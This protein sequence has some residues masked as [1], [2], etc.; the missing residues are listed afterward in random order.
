MKLLASLSAAGPDGAALA[1]LYRELGLNKSTCYNILQTLR[2]H[3]HVI[4]D[5]SSKRYTLGPVLVAL[6]LQ[7]LGSI[8]TVAVCHRQLL[9]LSRELGLTCLLT[10]LTQDAH[11]LVIDRVAGAGPIKITVAIGERL[12]LTSTA[13][14]RCFLA[15]VDMPIRARLLSTVQASKCVALEV[16]PQLLEQLSAQ[17]YAVSEGEYLASNNAVAAP[18]FDFRGNIRFAVVVVGLQE[19]LPTTRMHTVGPLV[20]RRAAIIT[21][22][23]GG[24]GP[25]SVHR[26]R[27]QSLA[28]RSRKAQS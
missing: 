7:A 14:G 8:D 11:V 1:T 17:G 13:A 6:G 19:Q 26:L 15:W 25:E 3:S 5:E 9:K 2:A 4:Y 10:S 27:P 22:A 21:A 12:A 24:R 28:C 18:V 23:I 20:S 16:T